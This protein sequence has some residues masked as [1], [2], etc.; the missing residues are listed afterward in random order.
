M[1]FLNYNDYNP[2]SS[3]C[4]VHEYVTMKGFNSHNSFLITVLLIYIVFFTKLRLM[5][6]FQYS[7]GFKHSAF[8]FAYES[9]VSKSN[10]QTSE[11]PPGSLISFLQKGLQY[12]EIEAHLQEVSYSTYSD[13]N[14]NHIDYVLYKSLIL[15]KS[16]TGWH[17]KAL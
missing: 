16:Y 1:W 7:L 9:L 2:L 4:K 14:V 17:R 12:V 5:R 13:D 10:I 6:A 8:T 11:V 3:N 15:Y